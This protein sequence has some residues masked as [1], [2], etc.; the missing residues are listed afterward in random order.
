MIITGETGSGKSTQVPQYLLDD[1]VQK[2]LDKKIYVT[3]PRRI[4]ATTIAERVADARTIRNGNNRG[5]DFN[6]WGSVGHGI[7]GYQVGLERMAS[8]DCRLLYMT[9]A[10][11]TNK[12][13]SDRQ[14]EDVAYLI[15]D[16]VHERDMDSE[17]LLLLVTHLLRQNMTIR[18]ILMSATIDAKTYTEYFREHNPKH[19]HAEGA[20]HH[21]EKKYYEEITEEHQKIDKNYQKRDLNTLQDDP[22]FDIN[23][24]Q[25]M[26]DLLYYIDKEEKEKGVDQRGSILIFLPGIAEINEVRNHIRR[27]SDD[28]HKQN[29]NKYKYT[30]YRL[31]SSLPR[32]KDELHKLMNPPI[33]NYRYDS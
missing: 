14:L 19:I 32:T 18:V 7:V 31:H 22:K 17:M 1:M 29:N 24:I 20:V 9:P 3:Q 30:I 23:Q 25:I 28:S 33:H 4:A 26:L 8:R 12:M 6:G 15:I 16:E 27:Y 2:N 11:V 10:I 21:V 5:N 13:Q